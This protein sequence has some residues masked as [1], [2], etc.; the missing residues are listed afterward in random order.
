MASYR[1]RWSLSL[2][3]VLACGVAATWVGESRAERSVDRQGRRGALPGKPSAPVARR[4]PEPEPAPAPSLLALLPGPGVER[5]LTGG[6]TD[7]YPIDLAAGQYLVA[8]FD[9]RGIDVTVEV[10]G[11]GRRRLFVVDSPNGKHGIESVH[12]V[13]DANGRYLMEVKAGDRDPG[14]RYLARVETLRPASAVDHLRFAAERALCEARVLVKRNPTSWEAAAKLEA[15]NRLFRQLGVKDRQAEAMHRLGELETKAERYHEALDLL[16]GARELYLRLGDRRFVAFLDDDIGKCE[17]A[18][19]EQQRALSAYRRSLWE[20]RALPPESGQANTLDSLAALLAYQGKAVEAMRFYRQED[21]LWHGLG[22]VAMEAETLVLI[23]WRLREVGDWDQALAMDRQALAMCRVCSSSHKAKV[24]TETALVYLG[25]D[26]PRRALP[27]LIQALE[28]QQVGDDLEARATTL[29][30]LALTHRRLGEYGQVLFAYEQS[31]RIHRRLGNRR[32][33]ANTWIDL[34]AAHRH[35]HQLPQAAACYGQALQLARATGYRTTEAEA[36]LGAG[37]VA[38]EEGNPLAA[39]RSGE[40]ALQIIE[41][42]RAEITR[43]DQRIGYLARNVDFYEFLVEVLMQLHVMQPGAGF[44]RRALEYGERMHARGLLEALAARRASRRKRPVAPA[45]LAERQRLVREVAARDL[46]LR[47][48][49]VTGGSAVAADP[50]M[51]ALL[52]QLREVEAQIDPAVAEARQADAAP[53]RPLAQMQRE[54]D[55]DTLLLEY[56]FGLTKTFLWAVTSDGIASFEL[57]GREDLEPLVRSTYALLSHHQAPEGEERAAKQ[58]AE[59]SRVLLGPVAERL[60]ERRLLIVA[61]GA[62]QYLPFAALPDPRNGVEPLVLHH[63]IVNVPSLGVL[64]SLRREAST[65]FEPSGP[66]AVIAD[67]VFGGQDERARP[68]ALGPLSL[69]PL[70]AGLPRLPYSRTE[71]EA[72]IALARRQGLRVLQALGFDANRELVTGG[73]LKAYRILHFATHGTLRADRPELSALALSQLD[74]FGHAHD[75]WLP[76][77]EI[78]DLDLPAELVVLSACDTA[79]G[80]ELAGEGLVGLPQGFMTAGAQRVLV[81]LWNVGDRSTAALMEHFYRSLLVDKLSPSAALCASQRAMWRDAHWHTPS[82]WA[83]FVL[84]GDWR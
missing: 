84:L 49:T 20:W 21:E 81:S 70:L 12:L 66:L 27:L 2:L 1:L 36:L 74:R 33:E 26:E 43:P 7:V 78:A 77:D 28:L 67:P 37:R 55:H 14:G 25:K 22:D 24:L 44:D 3:A 13:A 76:V 75:G 50:R 41:D 15:A 39:L 46:A 4:A 62:L 59:L 19:G 79:L 83:G 34:G 48:A 6:G 42:L 60:G 16:G 52:N 54:L 40:A 23:S 10:F 32:A 61:D 51:Q 72:I 63:E 69:D 57:R 58:A 31:I 9:Q 35:L 47:Q 53:S 30:N 64:Q 82:S 5:D 80:K 18:R 17:A 68:L 8:A 38:Q 73:H 56:C 65:R 71:A 11:P 45:L 29:T